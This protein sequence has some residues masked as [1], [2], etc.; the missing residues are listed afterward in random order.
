MIE[1]AQLVEQLEVVRVYGRRDPVL[2]VAVDAVFLA[3][4]R[5]RLTAADLPKLREIVAACEAFALPYEQGWLAAYRGQPETDNPYPADGS[6]DV[7]DNQKWRAGWFVASE[8]HEERNPMITIKR[9][10]ANLKRGCDVE[11]GPKTLI[12]GANG[13]GKSSI[14]AAIEFALTK[15]VSDVAGKG[16]I[17]TPAALLALAPGRT[18]EL[19]SEVVFDND[20]T[21]RASMEI[22]RVGAGS[23]V[24]QQMPSTIDPDRVHPV[25]SLEDAFA[26][27]DKAE[28]FLFSQVGEVSHKDVTS[29]IAVRYQEQYT[30]V[31]KLCARGPLQNLE[32]VTDYAAT[33]VRER[34]RAATQVEAAVERA[35]ANLPPP[36]TEAQMRT[37]E[38]AVAD[39]RLA[40]V[41]ARDRRDAAINYLK[42]QAAIAELGPRVAAMRGYDASRYERGTAM[43]SLLRTAHERQLETCA[44]CDQA[45]TRNPA[46]DLPWR[47]K[48]NA[49]HPVVQSLVPPADLAQL[50]HLEAMLAQAQSVPAAPDVGDGETMAAAEQLSATQNTL[51]QLQTLAGQW[52]AH[53]ATANAAVDM[54]EDAETWGK[55]LEACKGAR[56]SIVASALENFEKAVQR[57]LPPDDVFGVV[58][59]EGG[60][61]VVQYGF[62]REVVGERVLHTALSGAEWARVTCAMA[63][64]VGQGT[65]CAVVIPEERAFDPGTLRDVMKALAKAPEQVVL[66]SPVSYKGRAPAGWTVIDLDKLNGSA[67][68]SEMLD[69]MRDATE[70]EPE[71][72][73]GYTVHPHSIAATVDATLAD[74]NLLRDVMATVPVVEPSSL[75]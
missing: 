9:V 36:P 1:I 57:F 53:R 8:L 43:L 55:L 2:S 51:V 30:Q 45:V 42:A 4:Q 29:R 15:R 28:A 49:L 52:E 27:V 26:S 22:K 37:A 21:A 69:Q 71:P 59:N 40:L 44:F 61:K 23:A 33:K 12:V 58:L 16:S 56:R 34:S 65:P 3:C 31:A 75:L 18:G 48:H 64:V 60:R 74:P 6:R 72:E 66:T 13:A 35:A 46:G 62:W 73:E 32:F 54:E 14:V 11:L 47:D 20:E 7:S 63:A 25:R 19:W 10:R 70:P 39:A 24:K 41:Q 68:Y 67:E 38:Q 5:G 17:A 50:P